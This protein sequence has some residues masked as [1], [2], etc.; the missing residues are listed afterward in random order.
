MDNTV[1]WESIR[2]EYISGDIS[3]RA[4]AAKHGVAFTT[5]KTRGKAGRW[6][7]QRAEY[8]AKVAT[9]AAQKLASD[10]ANRA[11][12][13]I[14]RLCEVADALLDAVAAAAEALVANVTGAPRDVKDLAVAL[15]GAV[16]VVRDLY[17]IPTVQQ[18]AQMDIAWARLELERT[19]AHQG[20]VDDSEAGVVVVPEILPLQEPPK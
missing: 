4:L 1:N 20:V 14:A 17:G 11:A 15:Q 9:D 12:D 8:R 6:P 2:L 10:M 16:N 13:R 7:E 18:Q 19:R 5:L 3:Y